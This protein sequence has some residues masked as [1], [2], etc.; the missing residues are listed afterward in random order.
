MDDK[1]ADINHLPNATPTDDQ[2]D[3]P[4]PALGDTPPTNAD[5]S[6][7]HAWREALREGYEAGLTHTELAEESGVATGVI[8]TIIQRHDEP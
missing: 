8:R 2:H 5:T 6:T 4:P 3:T 1:P 7:V